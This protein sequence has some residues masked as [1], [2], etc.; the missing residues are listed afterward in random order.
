MITR[1]PTTDHTDN[2]DGESPGYL[3]IRVIRVIRGWMARRLLT[4]FGLACLL[5]QPLLVAETPKVRIDALGDALPVQAT[6]RFG[7]ARFCTQVEVTS[8]V[9]SADG[10]F[11]AAADREGRGYVWD[12]SS[13][14]E[15]L[16][17]N[18]G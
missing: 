13:G 5:C 4:W 11:L 7:T 18:A 14:K 9:M 6:H 16:R 2:T 15:R 8:L 1:H 3:P 17:T 10:K 12:A